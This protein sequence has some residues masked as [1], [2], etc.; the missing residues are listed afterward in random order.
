MFRKVLEELINFVLPN[1]C[2]SCEL[3]IEPHEKFI[4]QKCYQTL[5]KYGDT[6]PWKDEYIE[7][8]II[9][10]SLS[11]FWF[12]EGN[13]IQ[14]L[15]HAMKYQK[16]RSVGKMLGTEIGNQIAEVNNPAFDYII[17]VPLHKAKYRDRTYN[18]SEYIAKGIHDVTRAEVITDGVVR[19]R[20]TETQTRLNKAER[21]VNVSDAFKVNPKHLE[22]LKGKNIIVVDD[23]ITTGATI[24]ECA[25]ALR[26]SGAGNIWVCSAAYAELK[27][28]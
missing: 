5:E 14:S 3:P 21:K 17:P 15:M 23:V 6:H 4:C 12:R 7:S 13:V 9:T 2:L 11:A 24:L 19:T 28:Q 16:M 27:Q 1:S 10:N 25:G 20:F 26:L 8:G 18:Q 22:K